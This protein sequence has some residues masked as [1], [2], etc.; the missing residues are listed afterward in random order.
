M[1]NPI[2]GHNIANPFSS[3]V[4][5]PD[6][7]PD[8]DV[9][10]P[11]QG[12]LQMIEMTLDE[13]SQ[14]REPRII[15]VLGSAGAGK[16]S[17]YWTVRK[18]AN[19]RSQV[20]YISP[21]TTES[22]VDNLYA[23]LWSSLLD[24]YGM[25]VLHEVAHTL[26]SHYGSLDNAVSQLPGRTALVVEL[27]FAFDEDKFHQTAKYLFSGLKVDNPILPN[28]AR[29]F[30]EDDE[31][32]FQA[33]KMVLKCADRPI[34]FYFDEIESLFVS[35]GERPEIRLL[36]KI[37]RMYNELENVV[38]VLSSLP[39]VWERIVQLSTVSAVSRFENPTLIGRFTKED[40]NNFVTEKLGRYWDDHH[41][42]R[43]VPT[44]VWPFQQEELEAVHSESGGNPREAIKALRLRWLD[45]KESVGQY[46]QGLA[47]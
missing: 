47:N 20:V 1:M 17:L 11:K 40:L 8:I 37:K 24:Q 18:Y 31:L 7:E 32:C 36:E 3:Y 43:S 23:H 41:I 38:I 27:F 19:T 44:P 28:E 12:V 25:G 39:Q 29:S 2:A 42:T 14:T 15:P 10:R 4:A 21:Q 6:R 35:L 30:L 22:H 9:L 46:L 45:H 26:K 34:M 13:T 16:T 5:R 33:L